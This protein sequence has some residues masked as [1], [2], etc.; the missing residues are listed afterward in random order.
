MY[1][2]SFA[3]ET[4]GTGRAVSAKAS[5]S[6]TAAS[7]LH[8]EDRMARFIEPSS[9]RRISGLGGS[10]C[11]R[12]QRILELLHDIFCSEPSHDF[13]IP[14]RR[15]L[16]VNVNGRQVLLI[17]AAGCV[18]VHFQ[19][20]HASSESDERI[21]HHATL[22]EF[23]YRPHDD[24]GFR[25]IRRVHHLVFADDLPEKLRLSELRAQLCIEV[26]RKSR[27]KLD[28][29]RA[30]EMLSLHR[31]QLRVGILTACRRCPN[32][33]NSECEQC[34][35]FHLFLLQISPCLS[36]NWL[37]WLLDCRARSRRSRLRG[38][39]SQLRWYIER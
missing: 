14:S 10:I 29:L 13:F 37:V 21:L 5:M 28:A 16:H 15:N 32:Q 20:A 6:S 19:T 35:T 33:E 27:R 17:A 12:F 36:L 23:R 7:G 24:E 26:I 3:F 1:P 31:F 18:C 22:F 8:G 11:F 34:D 9:G 38:R 25:R 30:R 4:A 39:S 2:W